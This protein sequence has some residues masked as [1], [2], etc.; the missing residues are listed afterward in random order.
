MMHPLEYFA[1]A[2]NGTP[3]SLILRD[4]EEQIGSYSENLTCEDKLAFLAVLSRYLYFKQWV[5]PGYSIGQAI[6]D[7]QIEADTTPDTLAAIR[8]TA[9]ETDVIWDIL[10][11]LE[12]ISLENALGLLQF[13]TVTEKHCHPALTPAA[14]TCFNC[15]PDQLVL[16]HEESA[17]VIDPGCAWLLLLPKDGFTM[18]LFSFGQSVQSRSR[19]TIGRIIGMEFAPAGCEL[20]YQISPGWHYVIEV[21][22]HPNCL[23]WRDEVDSLPESDLIMICG[24]E[25]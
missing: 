13:I 2:P 22:E 19:E 7:S 14:T 16:A 25:N 17:S 1:S 5:V 18:P 12:G 20:A 21:T 11:T 6:A 4:I 23:N 3:D 9:S 8:D 10:L 24:G 15:T